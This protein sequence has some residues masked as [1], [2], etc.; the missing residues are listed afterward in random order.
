MMTLEPPRGVPEG[1]EGWRTLRLSRAALQRFARRAREAVGLPG[2]VDVLLT[3]DAVLKRLNREFRGKDKATDVLSFPAAEEVAEQHAG[4]L[5]ISLQ[6][7]ERQASR[8]GHP[9]EVELRVLMLHGFL[10]L[11]GMDHEADQG[12]MAAR[13]AHLQ[14]RLGL[15]VG[16]IARVQP[17][18]RKHQGAPGR[19]RPKSTESLSRRTQTK[20]AV[21]R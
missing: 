19:K 11:S 9:L 3:T 6:T 7:A 10:H 5:A 8:Y 2:D 15:P 20:A 21:T 17:T 4:D 16:L 1:A 18:E 12:E 14:E 13:E